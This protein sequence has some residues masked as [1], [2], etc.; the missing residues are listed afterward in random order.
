[1]LVH[2]REI[3]RKAEA[4]K[5]A[6]GAFNVNNLETLQ[7]VLTAAEK[8]KSPVIIQTTEGA[9]KYAGLEELTALVKAAAKETSV[10]VALHL[11]HGHDFN[12]IKKVIDVGYSS[13]MIDASD[14]PFDENVKQ[15]KRVV[16]YAHARKVF[17]QAEMGQLAGAEDWLKVADADV[18]FT[19]PV[20]ANKFVNLTK[21]DVL[22]PAIGNYHG[23]AKIIGKK[24]LKLHLKLLEKIDKLVSVP[25]ALHGASGFPAK[26]IKGAIKA[27]IRI[28]NI[29][30]ELRVSFVKAEK[31]FLAAN[32][33]EYDPR[34]VLTPAIHEMA[35]TVEK[36]IIMF[37]SRNK[38]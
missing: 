7:A 22:A 28:I 35:K 31:K 27:G 3:I 32:K 29:D 33:N 36:K 15:V 4:G 14:K 19:D 26:E 5:Y 16:R 34:K 38:A 8:M 25:M 20:E 6:V 17:V 24:K 2:I 18:L 30:S 23:V 11:D 1:M 21:I 10:P 13:V 12:L 37:G 9:I